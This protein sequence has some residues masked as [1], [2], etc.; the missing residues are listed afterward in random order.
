MELVQT[1][2]VRIVFQK[3][4]DIEKMKQTMLA[5]RDG[6]NLVSQYIFDHYFPLNRYKLQELLYGTLRK[7]CSLKS[8]MAITCIKATIAKY[9]TLQTTL[10]KT[11]RTVFQRTKVFGIFVVPNSVQTPST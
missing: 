5:Y 6:C 2:K 8:M 3:Q 4:E 11:K 1:M 9:K 10:Q 7:Q